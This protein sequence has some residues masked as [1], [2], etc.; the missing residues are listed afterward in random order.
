LTTADTDPRRD[1]TKGEEERRLSDKISEAIRLAITQGRDDISERLLLCRQA[2][3][4]DDAA[5]P[6]GRREED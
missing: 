1:E 2:V 5:H 4:E 6:L 3:A